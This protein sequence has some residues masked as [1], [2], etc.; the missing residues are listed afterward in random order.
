MVRSARVPA[1]LQ[2][3]RGRVLAGLVCTLALLLT[4]ASALADPV[5]GL[6]GRAA[7]LDAQERA[8]VVS[9]YG[10]QSRLE[11]AQSRI[12]GIRGRVAELARERGEAHANLRTAR[13]TLAIAE[14]QL[15]RTLRS[16]YE[17]EGNTPLAVLLGSRTL[18]DVVSRFD[19]LDRVARGHSQV[20][21]QTRQA[22]ARIARLVRTLE[23]REAETRQLE[24]EAVGAADSLTRAEAEKSAYLARVRTEQQITA[25]QIATAE[26]EARA[27]EARAREQAV[28]AEAAPSTASFAAV[29]TPARATTETPAPASEPEPAA[30]PPPAEEPLAEEVATEVAEPAP[31]QAAPSG[32]QTLTVTS[33]AYALSG[34]T[35]TGLPV[36][37]GVVAVD[38]SVIPLG[39]RMTI[40]G[41]G[42]GV[43]AD[44]GGA[45]VGLRIDVWVPT[46]EQAEA[47]G[48]RTVTITLH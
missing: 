17:E 23:A 34:S 7:D 25:E 32:Q 42:E 22:R 43:A 12:E 47:W 30:E 48:V 1:P 39:T 16:L 19:G 6:R 36:G 3:T 10:L 18:E 44:T 20:A 27:A 46:E 33:T 24:R 5:Q 35:A 15:G 29:P 31:V 37:W 41:Y 26:A 45:I 40:P 38:P 8:L 21:R 2:S 13:R 9:L 11:E 4:G 28:Q 14:Q